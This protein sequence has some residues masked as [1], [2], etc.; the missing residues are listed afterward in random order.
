MI[1]ARKTGAEL[2]VSRNISESGTLQKE[3][4]GIAWFRAMDSKRD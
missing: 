1:L 3:L 4:A 2:P